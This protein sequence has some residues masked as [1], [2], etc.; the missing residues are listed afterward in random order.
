MIKTNTTRNY[1][2]FILIFFSFT[3]YGQEGEMSVCDS[4][5]LERAIL[6]DSLIET[7]NL[8]KDSDSL[9]TYLNERFFGVLD[10][11]LD[12]TY[13]FIHFEKNNFRFYTQNSPTFENLFFKIQQMA[14]YKNGKLNFFHIGGSHVQADIY[15]NI[16]R[17]RL[18]TYWK[19]LPG[20]RGFVF[21]F[22]MAKTNNPWNYSFTSHNTWQ[23]HRS[24][25]HR[26]DSVHYGLL[27]MAASC[28]DSIIDLNFSYSK[29]ALKPPIDHVR[30]FH[31]K[32]ALNY[33]I[34]FDS[35][36]N[37][38]LSQRTNEKL[39]YT[40]TYFKKEAISFSV[41]F[42]RIQDTLLVD[43]QDTLRS[44]EVYRSASFDG[45]LYIYGMELSNKHPGISYTAIGVNGAGLYTYRDNESF[46]EQ[47]AISRPDFVVF[48]VGTND[49]NMTYDKFNPEE[50]KNNL[51][52][53]M[54]RVYRAN[55]DCAILL[56]VPNDAYYKRKYL[57]RNIAR[58]REVI[59]ELA[60]KYEVPVW[61]LYG[62][63]GELGSSKT[64]KNHGLM[65]ADFVHF[66]ADGYYLKGDIFFEAFMKWLEQME[67]RPP[68]SILTKG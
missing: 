40:D 27:G 47:L 62:I 38:V 50:Y 59:N 12:C 17:E 30:I 56:T 60:K 48:S 45:P 14:K 41:K 57:N 22:K 2:L 46:Q 55:P 34:Q 44:D 49:A 18:Q 20:D 51:E 23:G 65:K 68:I 16:I 13:P 15:T 43:K 63:M 29:S 5:H 39:G 21:P 8:R 11:T 53:M 61:D 1:I 19:D 6:H 52:T 36:L 7:Y 9:N 37:P 3:A 32:G 42:I 10:S 24:V 67:H 66:T 28:S 33:I 58:E 64:W 54:K 4:I 25:I 26:S 35:I 31:N